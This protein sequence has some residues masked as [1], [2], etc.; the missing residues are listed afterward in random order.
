LG[1]GG[2]EFKSRRPD[3]ATLALGPLL[4]HVGEREAVIWVETDGP[5]EVEVRGAR[6]RT[7]HVHGHHYALVVVEGLEPGTTTPYAVA[8]DGERAWP[9]E[10]EPKPQIRTL[11]RD[12]PVSV[13]FGSC[14]AAAP[15]TPE[16]EERYGLDAL[17]AFG[18]R[19]RDGG[20]PPHC[21]VLLGDQVYVDEAAP[22]T[23]SFAR[24]RR[25]TSRPPGEETADFEEYARLYHE[26]W[27][28]P[29]VRRLFATV[30]TAMIFDDHELAD[31]W[32]ISESWAREMKQK[33]WWS[34]RAIGAF[35]SYWLYQHLGNL[36]PQALAEDALFARVRE[37]DD[38]FPPLRELALRQLE[39]TAGTR[40]SFARQLG[41]SRLVV[42]D[43]R[44]GRVLRDG[45]RDML[46]P[47]EWAFVEAELGRD[48]DHVLVATSIPLLLGGGIHDFQAWNERVCGGAWGSLAA[49]LGEKLRR[50]V[51]LDHWASFQR[52]FLRLAQVLQRLGPAGRVLVLSGDVHYAYVAPATLPQLSQLVVSPLR[53]KLKTKERLA[54]QFALSRAGRALGAALAR[55]VDAPRPPFQWRLEHGPWFD[56]TVGVLELDGA[57]ARLRFECVRPGPRLETVL[58]VE[59]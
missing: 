11:D 29:V 57:R 28:D 31:D 51:D 22:Q 59:L 40:W 50:A 27:G 38:G 15:H 30:S 56:S 39:T 43:S 36:S 58:D 32:N 5:C 42:V 52:S 53:N 20:E 13:V 12:R 21:L 17:R 16:W 9:P 8:L 34:E 23:R 2:R 14:R 3:V 46:D 18:L 45:E 24:A 37:A 48:A 35:S 33:P 49:R 10:G 6:A 7:F 1:G 19:L 4:R 44:A 47:D 54:Q 41:R 55:S 26:S 25:D